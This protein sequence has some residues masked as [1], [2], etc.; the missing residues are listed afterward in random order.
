M[1]EL[2]QSVDKQP[3][4]EQYMTRGVVHFVLDKSGRVLSVRERR[5]KECTGKKAGDL[6]VLCETTE[7]GETVIDTLSRGLTEELGLKAEDTGTL[8]TEYM[9]G[10]EF[11]PGV[12]ADVF[13]STVIDPGLLQKR[14][15]EKNGDGE[16][17][18]F[19]WQTPQS[20]LESQDL[21]PGVRNVL[22]NFKETFINDSPS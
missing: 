14:I 7:I 22:L 9:G 1:Y 19:V 20:L 16:V 17:E 15:L 13:K 12:W 4:F 3:D 5:S 11:I 18:E 21:R 2:E 6:S 10:C 8:R